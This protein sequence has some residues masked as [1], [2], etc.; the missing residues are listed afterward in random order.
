LV[1]TTEPPPTS[2]EQQGGERGKVA[3][4]NHPGMG[5]RR[6]DV[7]VVDA[8]RIE[9]RTQLAVCLDEVIVGAASDPK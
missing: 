8:P 3:P 5:A 4:P 7:G 6:F 1:A 9:P 2:L